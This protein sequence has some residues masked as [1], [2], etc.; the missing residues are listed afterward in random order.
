MKHPLKLCCVLLVVAGLALCPLLA[1][2]VITSPGY[3]AEAA[4]AR[5][6]PGVTFREVDAIMTEYGG[7]CPG[8]FGP[9][10]WDCWWKFGDLYRVQIN[11]DYEHAPA[12]NDGILSGDDMRILEK[13]IRRPSLRECLGACWARVLRY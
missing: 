7:E 1:R 6:Q 8:N 12:S 4:F 10:D 9:S 2:C 11:L 13:S 3:R 5:I